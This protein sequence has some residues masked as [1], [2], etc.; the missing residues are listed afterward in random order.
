MNR[1]SEPDETKPTKCPHCNATVR[2]REGE[3]KVKCPQCER[4]F[5]P[6]IV[7]HERKG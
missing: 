5:A 7:T 1:H 2:V 4:F 6:H 3:R